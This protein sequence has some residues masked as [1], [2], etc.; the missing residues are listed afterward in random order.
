MKKTIVIGLFAFLLGWFPNM[1]YGHNIIKGKVFCESTN[2]PLPGATIMLKGTTEGTTTDEWGNF[3]IDTDYDSGT[4]IIM[5][6]GYTP[7]EIEFTSHNDFLVI[8]LKPDVV[9]LST[10]SVC[11]TKITPMVSIAMVDVNVRT[12]NSS[13][14]V[15][16]IVPGLF[17]AQH[18]GGGKSEQIFLRGFDTDHGTD[19]NISVDGLP[20]N[21]VS[22][23]HG[24]GYA[25]LHWLIP[26]LIREVD[27]GKGPYYADRGD[28]TTAGYVEFKT[29]N[30]LDKNMIK[31]EAGQFNTFRTVGLFNLLGEEARKSGK[32]AFV[33][34]EYFMTDGP[35]DYPQNFNRLN[36]FARYNMVVDQNN[37]FTVTGSIF[38]SKWDQSGQVPQSEVDEGRISRW[39]SLDPSEGGNTQRY[40]ISVKSFHQMNDGGVF[41]NLLYYTRYHFD[42]YSNFTF[43]L[44]DSING[45]QIRQKEKRNLYGYKGSYV[46]SFSLAKENTIE[47]N[48]G[49]G[50]RFDEI[51]NSQ[52]LNTKERY[53]ILD[54]SNFGDI[55][56]T[57]INLFGQMTWLKKKWMVNFGLR[58]DGFK[59][60]YI[61]KTADV[62]VPETKFQNILSPKLN[63]AF[64]ASN[65]VQIYA[66]LGQGFHSNDARVVTRTDSLPTLAKAYGADLGVNLKP[67]SRVIINAALW[68]MYLES[69]LVWSGDGGAWEPSGRTNRY[70]VDLSLRWQIVDWLFFD[71][72]INY[73]I[74]RFIDE[75]EDANYVPL[76]PIWTSTGGFTFRHPSGW[77]SSLRYRY[78]SD[79]PADETNEVTAL[80]YGVV[81]FKL[82]Y[83]YR[84]WTF[85]LSMENLLNTEW[86][87]AQFAGDYRVTETAE[88]EYGLTFTPGTPFF[89]KASVCFQF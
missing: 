53:M 27:F 82:N 29:I 59:F 14:D 21:M 81:D 64:N 75:P 65:N 11:A 8:G 55:F 22:Q 87:E 46:K 77:S 34:M 26:E 79:R 2:S 50:F 47:T 16:R 72:D 85:G 37:M 19:I 41:N 60:E 76:A 1:L 68:Y 57:N 30:V 45:D 51:I 13:Q 49:G 42:L 5:Y 15:L 12:V 43:F 84:K 3:T 31:L 23:A 83:T 32:N 63:V 18:A 24:Q 66:K 73:S 39:G 35:F 25:D 89:F 40:N 28:F 69:E 33:G 70:G 67:A 80:G 38:N 56:E 54:T 17:I 10:V 78:M 62:Y 61:D 6:I 52:L 7:Q 86:N 48:F 36:F 74:A 20:V 71:T 58:F 9:D 4:L 88:P 44:E